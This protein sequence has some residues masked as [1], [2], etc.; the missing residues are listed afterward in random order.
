MSDGES[1]PIGDIMHSLLYDAR[2]FLKHNLTY[3]NLDFDLDDYWNPYWIDEFAYYL[4]ELSDTLLEG[5]NR[6]RRTGMN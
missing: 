6:T 1:I 5:Q 3:Y 4:S 2:F